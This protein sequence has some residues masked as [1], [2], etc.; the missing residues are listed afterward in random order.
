MMRTLSRSDWLSSSD[1]LCFRLVCACRVDVSV[2]GPV[3][4][5]VGMIVL[6]WVFVVVVDVCADWVCWQGDVGEVGG[7]LLG[8]SCVL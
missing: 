1:C 5:S 8:A 7:V 4:E 6:Y 3:S 2:D